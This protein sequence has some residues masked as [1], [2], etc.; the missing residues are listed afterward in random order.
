MKKL[1]FAVCLITANAVFAIGQNSADLFVQSFFPYSGI[2]FSYTI[3][4]IKK[5]DNADLPL[6]KGGVAFSTVSKAYKAIEL[7]K[8]NAGD[9]F[10]YSNGVLTS[11]I[12]EKGKTTSVAI[13]K[14]NGLT[15]FPAVLAAFIDPYNLFSP[16]LNKQNFKEFA[17]EESENQIKLSNATYNIFFDKTSF[18]PKKIETKFSAKNGV[19]IGQKAVFESF[20]NIGG[21]KFPTKIHITY[22]DE[23]GKLLLNCIYKLSNISFNNI[24]QN[25]LK[26]D[27]TEGTIVNDTI[28][29]KKYVASGSSITTRE[30][31]VIEKILE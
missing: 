2:S 3:E 24:T 20:E 22:C 25:Q 17:V 10:S 29:N 13:T 8:N 28:Q 11:G 7:N 27:I 4:N 5:T 14:D 6:Q 23:N 21:V 16:I 30:E 18:L 26:I 9:C 1:I 15:N 31:A 19:Y 12:I